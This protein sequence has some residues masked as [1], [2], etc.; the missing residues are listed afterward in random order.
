V[1]WMNIDER[2]ARECIT[3]LDDIMN[4]RDLKDFLLNKMS[5]SH[6]YQPLV[7]K[8]LLS[9][10]GEVSIPEIA[11]EF[12]AYDQA[13]VSYYVSIVKRWPKIT[14]R[15]H[16]IIEC[17]KRGYFTLNMNLKGVSEVELDELINLCDQKIQDYIDKYKGIIGDYRYNPDDLS[18]KSIR[19]KVLQL[20]K[21]KCALCG[22]SIKDTPID[23]DHINPRS[24]GG[25]NSLDNLQALCF[26]CNRAKGNRDNVDFRKYGIAERDNQCEFC[27]NI[28]DRILKEYNTAISVNDNYPVTPFHNL[29]IP[30]RHVSLLRDLSI[31]EIQDLMFLTKAIQAKIEGE[32]NTIKGFNIG[33]NEGYVAGQ[34]IPHLHV[35]V[36]PR[37][38]NDV[39]D[40]TGGIR[41]II[42]VCK[43]E[44]QL[45]F[46]E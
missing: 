14:L 44:R 11:R 37:R 10:N 23:I 30:R 25:D 22:A 20:A 27:T 42:K 24:K 18:S 38:K 9:H 12:L 5:M 32:D 34:T 1:K 33:I 40:P 3:G 4:Y 35:H 45:A 21:G 39:K 29:I 17:K 26:R 19:Y 36:I 43:E 6:I 41:K 8:Q 2:S 31:E 15:K 16:G 28:K 7:I 13:Q 46:R